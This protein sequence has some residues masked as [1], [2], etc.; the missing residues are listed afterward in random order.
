M[1]TANCFMPAHRFQCVGGTSEQNHCTGRRRPTAEPKCEVKPEQLLWKV[2]KETA[3][4]NFGISDWIVFLFSGVVTIAATVYS[5]SEL[6]HLL[7]SGSVELARVRSADYP[8]GT[9]C[10]NS[11]SK[12]GLC[13]EG[14]K[15]DRA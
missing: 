12:R 7:G 1:P 3:S 8:R 6:F 11:L 2:C 15:R 13:G 4:L 5:F 14:P 10:V 9:R